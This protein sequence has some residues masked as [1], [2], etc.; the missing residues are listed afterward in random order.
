MEIHK[1][2]SNIKC[3]LQDSWV[4][5]ILL[6]DYPVKGAWTNYCLDTNLIQD[7]ISLW[8]EKKDSSP[9]E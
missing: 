6:H 7:I 2:D 9:K 3:T 1:K 8:C 5:F 4:P